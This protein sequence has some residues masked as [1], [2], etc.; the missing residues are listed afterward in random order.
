MRPNSW[1]SEYETLPI[2]TSTVQ[3]FA[4]GGPPVWEDC[5]DNICYRRQVGD[6]EAVDAAIGVA[7]H[8]TH[9]RLPISR[10]CMNPMEPRAALGHYDES[11]E[12]YTL[13]H[14]IAEPAR[15]AGMAGEHGARDT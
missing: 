11:T 6:T 2:V 8:V 9:T 1:R 5:P 7:A 13:L 14:R 15:H 4:E 12:R 10:V 3:A